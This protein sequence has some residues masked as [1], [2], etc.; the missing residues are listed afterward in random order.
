M[1]VF[2]NFLTLVCCFIYCG[3]KHVN[4]RG[5]NGV[6]IYPHLHTHTR[7]RVANDDWFIFIF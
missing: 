5:H 1:L 7:A 2:L 4:K 3:D 6:V